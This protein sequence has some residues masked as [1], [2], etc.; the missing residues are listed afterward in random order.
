MINDNTFIMFLM[1]VMFYHRFENMF[2]SFIR[3]L[4]AVFVA[5]RAVGTLFACVWIL[6]FMCII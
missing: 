3:V 1:S 4:A 2:L 5:H 6:Y